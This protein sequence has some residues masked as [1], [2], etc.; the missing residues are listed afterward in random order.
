MSLQ[1]FDVAGKR[2]FLRCDLN[3]PLKNGEI[4]DDGRIRASLPTIKTLLANGASI[5]IAPSFNGTF[6]S[7]RRNTRLPATSKF[8]SVFVAELDI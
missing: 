3:V 6:K 7:Q 1:N 4:T 5:V 8:C 2:V